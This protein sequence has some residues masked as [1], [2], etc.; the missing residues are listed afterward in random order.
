V[1]LDGH[2]R[3][4]EYFRSTAFLVAPMYFLSSVLADLPKLIG[5]SLFPC[6]TTSVVHIL[7]MSLFVVILLRV[8]I[9]CLWP[10]AGYLAFVAK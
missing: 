8:D 5:P 4:M 1:S 10:P 9:F 6:M 3:G 7:M 2:H